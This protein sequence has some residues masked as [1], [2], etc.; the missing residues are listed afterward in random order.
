MKKILDFILIFLLV[1]FTFQFF[2]SR[3]TEVTETGIQFAANE[4]NYKVPAAIFLNITNNTSEQ[5]TFNTC[6]EISIL[7]N[8]GKKELQDG[9]C[10]DVILDPAEKAKL[11]YSKIYDEFETPGEYTFQLELGEKTY[12][13]QINV[14]YRGTLGKVF[15]GVFYAPMYNLMAFLIQSFQHSLGWAIIAITIVIRILLLFPQHKM[16]VSQRKLQKIQPKIKELQEKHKGDAQ[17][18]GM[19]L[20]A[21]YK[22]EKVNPMGSCGFLIIQMPILLVIYNIIINIKN[23]AN[24]FYLYTFLQNFHIDSISYNFFGIDL[25]GSWGVVGVILGLS[26][27]AIQFIQIKLSLAGRE[28]TTKK[29][30]VVLEKKKGATDYNSMMP[31]PEMMNK[32]MLYWLPVMV[33]VFTFTLFA[34]VGIYWWVSTLFAIFQQL[35]VNKIIKK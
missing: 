1:F 23:P 29:S 3:N 14:K 27:A 11:D 24:E 28:D 6:D 15:T 25:L 18:L 34:W 16:M 12:I 17:K 21:L 8:G 26:V 4:T 9:F 30:G 10:S 31:D 35:F 33:W 32:F 20:M 5:I 19:E 22:K 2:Q 7:F 13:S